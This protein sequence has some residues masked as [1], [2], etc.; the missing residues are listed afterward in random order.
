MAKKPTLFVREATG[1][2]RTFSLADMLFY[3]LYGTNWGIVLALTVL[4]GVQA[5]PGA[6]IALA[7]LIGSAFVLIDALLSSMVSVAI[8]RSVPNYVHGKLYHTPRIWVCSELGPASSSFLC[9][10]LVRS[11]HRELRGL[12]GFR[13]FGVALEQP[14]TH[15][16]RK[17]CVNTFLDFCVW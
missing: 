7:V 3:N 16:N 5:F 9:D 10:R 14:N 1:L 6:N 12:S 13:D 17:R 8:P 15:R 2:V 4:V 11:A